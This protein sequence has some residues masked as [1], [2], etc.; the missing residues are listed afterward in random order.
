MTYNMLHIDDNPRT[1]GSMSFGNT[2][3]R[4]VTWVKFIDKQ[5]DN[6]FYVIN[7]HLAY[8]SEN[9]RI[10]GAKLIREQIK[11]FDSNLPVFATGDFNTDVKT[12]PYQILTTDGPL[13]DKWDVADKHIN[14]TLGTMNDFLH[15]DGGDRRIDWILARGV[16]EVSM[17]KIIDD[18]INGQFPSD[19]FPV[20]I[21]CN[22]G[23]NV[24][25]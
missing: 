20:I 23:N 24:E 19:H 5:T 2:V 8:R 4:M 14:K 9:G 3:P 15:E 25:K 11:D 16:E 13:E 7:T 17:I 21:H 12:L 1:I 22:I 10:E 6:Q 18:Y